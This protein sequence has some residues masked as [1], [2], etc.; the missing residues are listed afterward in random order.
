MCA[1]A[2]TLKISLDLVFQ[3]TFF[4]FADEFINENIMIE[5]NVKNASRFLRNVYSED[6]LA[7]GQIL[8][9]EAEND[10]ETIKDYLSCVAE[11]CYSLIDDLA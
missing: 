1:C 8:N 7:L 11:F 4:I 6:I 3:K 10:K 2:I 5:E 9:A